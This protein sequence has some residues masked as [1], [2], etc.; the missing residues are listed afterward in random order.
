MGGI[1]SILMA[2]NLI[3]AS[4]AAPVFVSGMGIGSGAAGSSFAQPVK[5]SSK[6]DRTAALALFKQSCDETEWNKAKK[7]NDPAYPS[8]DAGVKILFD[9][10]KELG[11]VRFNQ[12]CQ[13][14]EK[15]QAGIIFV[16]A[17]NAKD[18]GV[19]MFHLFAGH[20]DKRVLLSTYYLYQKRFSDKGYEVNCEEDGKM[21][22]IM[23]L[24]VAG[25]YMDDDGQPTGLAKMALEDDPTAAEQ[26]RVTVSPHGRGEAED[27]ITFGC[28][29]ITKGGDLQQI[30]PNVI[31]TGQ[32]DQP[33]INP[34]NDI[35]AGA[36][37]GAT[38][39][40]D[41]KDLKKAL[42]TTQANSSTLYEAGN[43]DVADQLGAVE[44]ASGIED[45]GSQPTI[46]PHFDPPTDLQNDTSAAIPDFAAQKAAQPTFEQRAAQFAERTVEL[47]YSLPAGTLKDGAN[48][49]TIGKKA[50]FDQ[51]GVYLSDKPTS[52][53]IAS[54]AKAL[55][56]FTGHSD[57][58]ILVPQKAIDALKSGNYQQA[59]KIVGATRLN[60]QFDLGLSDSGIDQM[61]QSG[62][63]P[64]KLADAL[65]KK[66]DFADPAEASM[67]TALATGGYKDLAKELGKIEDKKTQTP[68]GSFT[69]ALINSNE[70]SNAQKSILGDFFANKNFRS[71]IANRLKDAKAPQAVIDWVNANQN[72]TDNDAKLCQTTY[73]SYSNSSDPKSTIKSANPT[74][75][76]S[77]IK[78]S[79]NL[80]SS[81]EKNIFQ[82]VFGANPS[83]DDLKAG[84]SNGKLEQAGEAYVIASG[85]QKAGL[86][87][88]QASYLAVGLAQDRLTGTD[89]GLAK[90]NQEVGSKFG[91]SLTKNDLTLFKNGNFAGA[92]KIA[93]GMVGSKT[94]L[95]LSK[96]MSAFTKNDKS[97]QSD[98]S[99][100]FSNNP[101]LASQTKTMLDGMLNKQTDS[102]VTMTASTAYAGAKAKALSVSASSSTSEA[103]RAST[104]DKIKKGLDSAIAKGKTAA[105]SEAK[106]VLI[107][108]G[109]NE[110]EA[111]NI[112]NGNIKG[113]EKVA[114]NAVLAKKIVSEVPGTNVEEV[115]NV[116]NGKAT[117]DEKLQ[118]MDG[119]IANKLSQNGIDYTGASI[120]K[121]LTE[122]TDQQKKDLAVDLGNQYGAA[123]LKDA[124]AQLQPPISLTKDQSL[125][126]M[127]GNFN[128][129]DE[130]AGQS[131]VA[132]GLS[133]ITGT[134]I[135]GEA[136]SAIYQ[137]IHEQISST[138]PDVI[139]NASGPPG[140]ATSG[141]N[142]AANAAA[143]AGTTTD[144][145]GNKVENIGWGYIQDN[146]GVSKDAITNLGSNVKNLPQ[147]MI[148]SYTN[149]DYNAQLSSIGAGIILNTLIGNKLAEMDP[150]GGLLAGIAMQYATSFIMSLG[151]SMPI[152]LG[153]AF[154]INPAATIQALKNMVVMALQIFTDPV[155]AIM[156]FLGLGKKPK[157]KPAA[158][159]ED[160]AK[161]KDQINSPTQLIDAPTGDPASL[162]V[163]LIESAYAADSTSNAMQATSSY[164]PAKKPTK[165]VFEQISRRT[166]D[167]VLE[168]LLL[169][170]LI[171]SNNQTALKGIPDLIKNHWTAYMGTMAI[172][173]SSSFVIKQ[174]ITPRAVITSADVA[175]AADK[176]VHDVAFDKEPVAG[177]TGVQYLIS[178]AKLVYGKDFDPATA[179]ERTTGL[180]VS[181]AIK[182]QV[183]FSF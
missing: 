156:G 57:V 87:S 127:K 136:A 79:V 110:T 118:V 107:E 167:Q 115:K 112:L 44:V 177:A 157:A 32:T 135:S 81:K 154:L 93:M 98:I 47:K 49:E 10:A 142:S 166:T 59:A 100:A 66:S 146:F 74:T 15:G 23:T 30:A 162:N 168:D 68:T 31:Q 65:K 37:A 138:T 171:E 84:F 148:D 8:D 22:P 179:G 12:L 123:Q 82:S 25:G 103:D 41:S 4:V 54:A 106:D 58:S 152:L 78:A 73:T 111:N 182:T 14:R 141:A 40:T 164:I 134:P 120:T 19:E 160:K 170:S 85:L 86:A 144:T 77:A 11:S 132:S 94:N 92:Q 108:K 172:P 42:E 159:N 16:D 76:E 181:N 60:N 145:T 51:S 176:G 174:I 161:I 45:P 43:A 101:D 175:A 35:D 28:T 140:G 72:I 83:G 105:K 143:N 163:A 18:N 52:T 158:K 39:A 89:V 38:S 29:K 150:T 6:D 63:T 165:E 109:L 7:D 21:A 3:V 70:L 1:L 75:Y 131:V 88:S 64:Q 117:K 71:N 36:L 46:M 180:L 56:A 122:G 34:N 5:S 97:A 147:N 153:I 183:H 33:S 169:L 55:S 104:S 91:V 124:A 126:F 90:I 50:L 69:N 114:T 121:T 2:L 95:P 173:K 20:W 129:I 130:V 24:R 80:M 128:Q 17:Q 102:G 151:I 48:L 116:L 155:G 178:L 149:F 96:I 113:A 13:P 53:E 26:K 61:A 137:A 99:K 27:I 133:K 139:N 9:K 125:Q 62:I 67:V 119:V